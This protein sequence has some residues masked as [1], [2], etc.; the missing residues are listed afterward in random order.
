MVASGSDVCGARVEGTTA[1]GKDPPQPPRIQPSQARPISVDSVSAGKQKGLRALMSAIGEFL[2][3]AFL[4]KGDI[5][6]SWT[7][8][9]VGSSSLKTL[10]KPNGGG[11][12]RK[13]RDNAAAGT[14]FGKAGGVRAAPSRELRPRPSR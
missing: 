7:T 11:K 5:P 13:F 12:A 6:M 2:A 10:S 4:D 14:V 1:A 8:P 9:A 3:G